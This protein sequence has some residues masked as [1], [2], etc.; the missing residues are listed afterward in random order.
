MTRKSTIQEK[1]AFHNHRIEVLQAKE[2]HM[3]LLVALRE[4]K[5]NYSERLW[6][7]ELMRQWGLMRA[8]L[9]GMPYKRVEHKTRKPVEPG[10]T[11]AANC[12]DPLL[13]KYQT[14]HKAAFAAWLKEE[15][16]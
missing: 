15:V 2:R 10:A 13:V 14:R 11:T 3:E 8:F 4:G 9:A 16:V 12:A 1:I 6:F 7:S 5:L